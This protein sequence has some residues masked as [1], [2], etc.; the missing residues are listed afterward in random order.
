M[1]DVVVD[2]RVAHLLS[3]N[4]DLVGYADIGGGGGSD[5]TY[6]LIGG[7]NWTFREGFTTKLGYQYLFWD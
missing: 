7:I 2:T 3:A 5:L 6:Q 1:T 4:V